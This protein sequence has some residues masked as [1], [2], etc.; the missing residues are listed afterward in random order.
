MKIKWR[1]HLKPKP[2]KRRPSSEEDILHLRRTGRYIPPPRKSWR[3]KFIVVA[4]SPFLWIERRLVEPLAN[5]VD[6]ADVFRIL[7]KVGFLIAVLVFLLEVG[8][9]REKSIFEAWQVVKDG[10]GEKSGVVV[11]A[12]ER[13]KKENFSLSGINVEKTNLSGAYLSNADLSNA[14]LS[15]AYIYNANLNGAL[16]M[17]ANLRSA[18][19]SFANLSGADFYNANLKGADLAY[20]LDITDL[21]NELGVANLSGAKNLTP[22]QVKSAK[23]WEQAIYDKE[24]RAKLGLPPEPMK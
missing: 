10:Q 3:D 24:F 22:E 1:S 16:L 7:E 11:L 21:G 17:G 9:R 23:N 4:K 20:Q 19:L 12:L 6:G 15:F 5:L 13:L 18:N 8:E 2:K 14:N